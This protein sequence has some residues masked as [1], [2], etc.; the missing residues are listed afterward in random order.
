MKRETENRKKIMQNSPEKFYNSRT[1]GHT[2]FVLLQ[3]NEVKPVNA[4][5]GLFQKDTFF[6]TQGM[7]G[8]SV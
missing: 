4:F 3:S 6:L 2:N 5:T 8:V 7:K 1:S